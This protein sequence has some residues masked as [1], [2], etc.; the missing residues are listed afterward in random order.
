M[1]EAYKTV[2]RQAE[3]ENI[4]EKSRF[5]GYVK[6]V[7]SV[8]EAESFISEIK[9][10]NRNATH[11]VP[12][13]IIGEKYEIQK[14]SDD[15]E[16]SGTAGVPVLQMLLR[17]G[18]TNT[19]IVVTRYF[20]GIKLGTG[21]LVRAYTGTAQMAL[22]KARLAYVSE[23]DAIKVRIDYT[24]LGKFQNL[25]AAGEFSIRDAIFDDAVTLLLVSS[26]E[27]TQKL[28]ETIINITNGTCRITE[29]KKVM[30]KEEIGYEE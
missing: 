28:K 15:G 7:E 8:E 16:P 26:P 25:E 29:E 11:N 20:G 21:G 17:E 9:K 5:I 18:I 19:A 10:I 30:F 12:V 6:P 23:F 13:Y 24:F 1:A 14:C 22:R 2:S 4:I 27:K 3:I